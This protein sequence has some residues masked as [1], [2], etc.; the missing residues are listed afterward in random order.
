MLE[1][2]WSVNGKRIGLTRGEYLDVDHGSVES[3][4]RYISKNKR[5]ARSWRQS[6]GLEK[7]KT[8]PPND[9]KW[10][11]RKLDE[12]STMYID[13]TEFWEKKYPGYTLNRVETRVSN[14]G[15]RHT[16]VIMRRAECRNG[17]PGRKVTPR[18][19]R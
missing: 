13:D 8:P 5:C 12:A 10:S 19:N 3:L 15:W 17:T 4:V 2:L 18:M 14:A 1:E 7:P 16:T 11:R 9:S 6:R